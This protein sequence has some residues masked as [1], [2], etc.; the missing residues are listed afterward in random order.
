MNFLRIQPYSLKMLIKNTYLDKL[1]IS[2]VYFSN[3][4]AD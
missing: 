2:I 3:Q 4:V 1:N